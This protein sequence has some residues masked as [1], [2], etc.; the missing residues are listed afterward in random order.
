M[1]PTQ[2]SRAKLESQRQ[3]RSSANADIKPIFKRGSI[4]PYICALCNQSFTRKTTVKEPHFASCVKVNGNPNGVA[5]DDHPSCYSKRPDGTMGPS[6]TVPAG[7][8]SALE[9]NEVR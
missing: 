4:A 7:L 3:T 2:T 9:A 5:W 6:G 8:S 1:A